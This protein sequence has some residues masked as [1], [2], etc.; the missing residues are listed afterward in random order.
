MKTL[1]SRI[2]GAAATFALGLTFL[3]SGYQAQAAANPDATSNAATVAAVSGRA[4]V[5]LNGK[6]ERVTKGMKISQGATIAT[7]LGRVTLDMG[8]HGFAEVQPR[9]EV[10]VEELSRAQNKEVTKFNLK[11]GILLGDVKKVAAESAYEVK[12]AKGVAGIRGTTYEI[13]AIGIFKCGDG[14]YQVV[15]I[16]TNPQGQVVAPIVIQAGSKVDVQKAINNVIVD[17]S[18]REKA[19]VRKATNFVAKV[20][21]NGGAGLGLVILKDSK[22]V[23]I[24]PTLTG[25][26]GKSGDDDSNNNREGGSEGGFNPGGN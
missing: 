24:E 3:L 22:T 2:A 19:D 1:Q 26:Q 15:F 12:T 8:A 13:H 25:L 10:V 7:G 14:Q 16:G 18:P 21:E 9:S 17:M 23:T 11:K 20:A 4:T 5:F 6:S